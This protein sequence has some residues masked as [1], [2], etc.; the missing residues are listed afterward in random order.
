MLVFNL[1]CRLFALSF[2]LLPGRTKRRS[3]DGPSQLEPGISMPGS[4]AR[5]STDGYVLVLHAMWTLDLASFRCLDLKLPLDGLGPTI[6]V[7]P[8]HPAEQAYPLCRDGGIGRTWGAQP[9][10]FVQR[11]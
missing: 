4:L 2:G 9:L 11:H 3:D 5:S 7:V 8:S 6:V 1:N 10:R